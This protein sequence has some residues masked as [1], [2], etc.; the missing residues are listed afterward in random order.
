MTAIETTAGAGHREVDGDAPATPGVQA[1]TRGVQLLDLIASSRRPPRYTQLL[2]ETGMPKGTLHRLLQ[3]L[4]EERLVTLDPRDQTYRLAS[5]LFE[6]AHKV[7]DDFD[8]RGAAEPEL[9]RLR[10]LSGE[11]V[12]LGMLDQETVL[13][14]DQR[15]VPWRGLPGR[16][17][18][19]SRIIRPGRRVPL[20]RVPCRGRLSG[21][22]QNPG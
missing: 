10:D 4:V 5:R 9:E 8:L 12:R 3:A 19:S 1:L 2:A 18:L 14:I 11:A 6:W 13:Y 20:L 17:T 16:T 21:S 22:S 7:W 15:E